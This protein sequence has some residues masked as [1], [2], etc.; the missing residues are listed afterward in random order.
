MKELLCTSVQLDVVKLWN[1]TT[2]LIRWYICWLTIVFSLVMLV[3][4]RKRGWCKMV[5][6]LLWCKVEGSPF[7]DQ[8]TLTTYKCAKCGLRSFLV[9]IVDSERS[10]I[11]VPYSQ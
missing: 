6:R 1:E 3:L 5:K 10:L 9:L 11:I 4:F 2:G 7:G 8:S